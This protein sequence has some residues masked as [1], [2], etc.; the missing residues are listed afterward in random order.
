MSG[1]AEGP[2]GGALARAIAD[3]FGRAADADKSQDRLPLS[4]SWNVDENGSSG[5]ATCDGGG[6]GDCVG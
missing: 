4:R 2:G 3:A 1:W 6:C 5:C